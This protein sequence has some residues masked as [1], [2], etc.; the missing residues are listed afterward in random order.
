[1]PTVPN[2]SKEMLYKSLKTKAHILRC[3]NKNIQE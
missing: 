2:L 1:M 3:L